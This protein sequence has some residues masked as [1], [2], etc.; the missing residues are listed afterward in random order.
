MRGLFRNA[1]ML[2]L[3]LSSMGSRY[4]FA[5]NAQNAEEYGKGSWLFH[6]CQ[7]YIR[8]MDNPNGV[9]EINS[10]TRCFDYLKGFADGALGSHSDPFCPGTASM[11]TIV[12]V[13]VKFME[14]HPKLLDEAKTIGLVLALKES[15]PCKA[16]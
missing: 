13:Y 3:I 16:K 5:Q 6:E 9:T 4:S 8:W 2:A 7:G 10:G 11:G 1:A 14:E 15:Y 12:R